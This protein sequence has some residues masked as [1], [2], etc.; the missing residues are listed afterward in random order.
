MRPSPTPASRRGGTLPQRLRQAALYSTLILPML[1]HPSLMAQSD[2][3]DDGKDDGW[4]RFAPLELL[5]IPSTVT[6]PD[7]GLGGKAYRLESAAPPVPNFGPAR[8]GSRPLVTY[9]DFTAAFDLIDWDNDL[10][11]SIGLLF[12][13][14]TIGIGTTSGFAMNYNVQQITGGPGQIQFTRVTAEVPS[15]AIR[16]ANLAL[17]PG[18]RYRF[19]FTA[20]AAHLAGS[21][22]DL[23]D[24][25]SPL[26]EFDTELETS[27]SGEV[28]LFNFNAGTRITDP[29]AGRT[30]STFDNYSAATTDLAPLNRTTF[31]APTSGLEFTATTFANEPIEPAGVTV[32]LNEVDRSSRLGFETTTSGLKV[33]LNELQPNTVY[34]AVILLKTSAGQ[35]SRTEW[36][37]DTFSEEFLDSPEVLVIEAEDYNFSRGQFINRPPAS[38]RIGND[39][40]L[41]ASTGYVDRIGEPGIDY[42]DRSGTEGSGQIPAYRAFDTV[43]TQAGSVEI[44]GSALLG[45]RID[46][47]NDVI[48]KKYGSQALPEYQ[49]RGTEG[50]E[51]LNYTREFPPGK[52]HVYLR[53]ASRAP[54]QIYLDTV[55]SSASLPSQTTSRLGTFAVPNMNLKTNYRFV[56]LTDATGKRVELEM[57]GTH[58]VRLT[59]GGEQ[60][61]RTSDTLA[62]NYMLFVPAD[63]DPPV[64]ESVRLESA[65]DI[66]GPFTPETNALFSG[67]TITIPITENLRF[68]RL[69]SPGQAVLL[70][71]EVSGSNLVL[72]FRLG[73]IGGGGGI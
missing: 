61:L 22:Y 26:A 54:Q 55:N 43:G 35:S 4:S 44:G 20:K 24:L 50:G 51:W 3:F 27:T 29:I 40:I 16:F 53:V 37:F 38:G 49:V 69:V 25:T 36:T 52:H 13:A 62:L 30:D 63:V 6:F 73:L 28:G 58:T 41:N 68:F 15:S 57:P 12:R 48:R 47:V 72:R 39:S 71:T 19:V 45:Q 9:S 42:F 2:N 33:R 18:H 59:M 5:G 8:I 56:P 31:F 21:V 60:T 32:L 11:Q 17:E 14:D 23:L 67:E 66:S 46:P 7:D 70:T 34:D 64:D 1:G 10:D 65:T